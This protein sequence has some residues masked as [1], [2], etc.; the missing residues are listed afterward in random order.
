LIIPE[1]GNTANT[2]PSPRFVMV[3]CGPRLTALIGLLHGGYH[4]SM[5]TTADL[6]ADVWA[7][8]SA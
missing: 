8:T 5:H 2:T 1:A 6:L 7:S 3:S 4:L